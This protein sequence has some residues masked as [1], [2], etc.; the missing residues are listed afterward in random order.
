MDET[1]VIRKFLP[2]EPPCRMMNTLVAAAV[3]G[4]GVLVAWFLAPSLKLSDVIEIAK[5]VQMPLVFNGI[6]EDHGVW[7]ALGGRGIDTSFLYGD[8]Q[9]EQVGRAIAESGVAREEIFLITKVACCPTPRCSSFCK[10]PPFPNNA[11]AMAVHNATEQLEHSLA[12]LQQPYADLVLMHFPCSDFRDTLAMWEDLIAARD[13]G[14]TRAIGVSNFNKTLLK[15]LLK[16]SK[17]KPAVVQNA[18]SVAGHPPSHLGAAGPCEEGAPL[19]GSDLE[20]FDYCRRQRIAF[21]AYSP[22]GGISKVDVLTQPAVQQAAQAH[23]KSAAQIALKYL[24]QQ[25]IAAVTATTKPKH[26]MQALDL[27]GF[28]LTRREMRALRAAGT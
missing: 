13:R 26:M 14:W 2:S 5:G 16:A 27:H 11:S 18:F 4:G 20:T 24:V 25:K 23:G 3:A 21:S 6:S 9:Q 28:D 12:V 15:R 8:E 7:L 1:W 10:D 17:V 22:L 19:Y